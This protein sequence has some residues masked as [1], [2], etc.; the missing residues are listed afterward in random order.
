LSG[1]IGDQVT[2]NQAEYTAVIIGLEHL[3]STYTG[4]FWYKGPHSNIEVLSDS[5]LVV[6][7]LAGRW[8]LKSA[9]LHKLYQKAMDLVVQLQA[10]PGVFVEFKQI[11]GHSGIPDN[12]K[13]DEL[14]GKAV[15]QI[16]PAPTWMLELIAECHEQANQEKGH[17]KLE[18]L[19]LP[20]LNKRVQVG[21]IDCT[22]SR[23]SLHS[24][25]HSAAEFLAYMP[26]VVVLTAKTA[27]LIVWTTGYQMVDGKAVRT[28]DE[29]AYMAARFM[30]ASPL[31]VIYIHKPHGG[32]RFRRLNELGW[33]SNEVIEA[34]AMVSEGVEQV[35]T[36]QNPGWPTFVE[37]E[38]PGGWT[39]VK[40]Y[41]NKEFEE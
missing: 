19:I 18:K 37:I 22:I 3:L 25:D 41:F 2:N 20:W 24:V 9:K 31:K 33:N 23:Q 14:A 40:Y 29:K 17:E 16:I 11:K 7:Q 38:S 1:Y 28:M 15:E 10:K 34:P 12:E 21:R 30:S 5:Q 8:A 13:A 27:Y 35:A 39:E 26:S 32:G 6:E 36:H 4:T